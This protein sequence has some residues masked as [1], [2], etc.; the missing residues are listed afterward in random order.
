MYLNN[1]DLVVKFFQIFFGFDGVEDI[2]FFYF[3]FLYKEMIDISDQIIFIDFIQRMEKVFN[4]D[5]VVLNVLEFI[6]VMR[7]IEYVFQ[8]VF[9]VE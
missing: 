9:F 4:D 6:V 3:D 2:L 8:I 1:M 5:M 7:V